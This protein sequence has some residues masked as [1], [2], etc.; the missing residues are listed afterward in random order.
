MSYQDEVV[1]RSH[2]MQNMYWHLP[3]DAS[4]GEPVNVVLRKKGGGKGMMVS[5]FVTRE[6]G[7]SFLTDQELGVVNQIRAGKGLDPLTTLQRV[8]GSDGISRHYTYQTFEFGKGSKGYWTAEHVVKQVAEITSVLEFKFPNKKIVFIFDWSS[9]HDKKAQDAILLHK[10]GVKWGGKAPKMRSTTVQ[11]D[12]DAP[13]P[14]SGLPTLGISDAKQTV[15]H[16]VFQDGDPPP[17]YNR[18]AKDYV[19]CA[20]GLKQILYERGLWRRNMVKMDNDRPERSM[21]HQLGQCLD[22]QRKAKSI[23][24]EEAERLGHRV[25]FLPKFHPELNPIERC[26]S[27]SKYHVHRF[28]DEK[29]QTMKRLIDESFS[30]ENMPVG[31]VQKYFSHADRYAQQYRDGCSILQAQM[32]MKKKSHRATPATEAR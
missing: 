31:L 20:K 4:S 3:E 30:E 29:F 17:F 21:Q 11:E 13:P 24:E 32:R 15:Q 27:R 18:D 9:N 10:M 23:L 22:F 14:R 16:L 28:C 6:Q 7:F 19:G 12:F 8:V 25:D 1:F 26:W 2:E 5:G